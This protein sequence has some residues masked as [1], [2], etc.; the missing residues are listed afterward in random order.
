MILEINYQFILDHI[1]ELIN[2]EDW[3]P[4]SF[5]NYDMHHERDEFLNSKN[6]LTSMQEMNELV[7]QKCNYAEDSVKAYNSVLIE[8]LNCHPE[9]EGILSRESF[10]EYQNM[11]NNDEFIEFIDLLY[12]V[13]VPSEKVKEVINKFE[14]IDGSISV[15][16]DSGIKYPDFNM[17]KKFLDKYPNTLLGDYLAYLVLTESF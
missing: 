7:R 5:V 6:L 8:W 4:V 2:L 13:E 1:Q 12:D 10:I 16:D 3:V 11:K 9:F 14:G 17:K 15:K